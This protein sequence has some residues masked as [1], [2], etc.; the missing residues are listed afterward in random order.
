M[1]NSYVN[2]FTPTLQKYYKEL[3]KKTHLSKKEERNLIIDAKKNN[4]ISSRNKLLES[5][6]KFVFSMAKKYKGRG[7]DM[8]ELISV[9]NLGLQMAFDKFDTRMDVK[10]ITYAMF[11]IKQ[12][13]VDSIRNKTKIERY[14]TLESEQKD[15]GDEDYIIDDERFGYDEVE[16]DDPKENKFDEIHDSEYNSVF[17]D[18]ILGFLTP[19]M[20]QII[21]GY[22]NLDGRGEKDL[23]E[24]SEDM[25]LSK[26]RV[27]Q[28]KSSALNI[29]RSQI[30]TL[31]LKKII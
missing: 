24:L 25:G 11:W 16:T 14:E 12:A 15:C 26:E 9:G 2:D 3:S 6:L 1:Q 31:D 18:T 23:G 8:E 4:N 28:I 29:I 30:L 19:R 17:V 7:V 22:Y 21:V 10:F 27:R 5:N 13:M 20:R